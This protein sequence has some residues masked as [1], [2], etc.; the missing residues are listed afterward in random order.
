MENLFLFLSV[1]L[2]S[3]QNDEQ[4]LSWKTNTDDITIPIYLEEL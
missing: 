4:S 3:K 1:Y 2:E